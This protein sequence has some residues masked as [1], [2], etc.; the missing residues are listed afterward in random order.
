MEF[1]EAEEENPLR[2]QQEQMI[3]KRRENYERQMLENKK[4][5]EKD[6]RDT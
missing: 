3:L 1:E 6:M 5:I 4:Q 2:A